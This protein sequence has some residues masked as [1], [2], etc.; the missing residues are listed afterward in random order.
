MVG[1]LIEKHIN[2]RKIE[3][4]ETFWRGMKLHGLQKRTN[5]KRVSKYKQ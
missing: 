2:D 3:L 4:L 1:K 5:G